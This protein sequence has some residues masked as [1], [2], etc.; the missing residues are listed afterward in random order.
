MKQTLGINQHFVLNSNGWLSSDLAIV[1]CERSSPQGA[2]ELY[3]CINTELKT[4]RRT[5]DR[6]YVLEFA[7]G[8]SVSFADED[9]NSDHVFLVQTKNWPNHGDEGYYLLD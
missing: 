5:T 8:Q 4:A 6:V 7:G 9:R 3:K 2:A 1:P